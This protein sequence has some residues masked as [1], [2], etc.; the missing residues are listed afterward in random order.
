M[1]TSPERVTRNGYLVA[2]AGEVMTD[3]EAERRGLLSKPRE[4]KRRAARR[5]SG[6]GR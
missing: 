3:G 4:Q 6:G 2:Y 1:Y 5:K